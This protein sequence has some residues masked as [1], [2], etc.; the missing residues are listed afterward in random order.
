MDH[1][2]SEYQDQQLLEFCGVVARI[3]MSN[4]FNKL[5]KEMIRYYKRSDVTNPKQ[6]AYQ[7]ALFTMFH[8]FL[9]ES[10][11]LQLNLM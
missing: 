8:E 4:E 6:K 1:E 10:Q 9:Q 7:D 11:N 5:F 3:C 2:F